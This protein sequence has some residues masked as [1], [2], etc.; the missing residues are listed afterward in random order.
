MT[1]SEFE[2][3]LR[4]AGAIAR[5]RD[6]FLIGS[7]SLRGVKS[8]IPRDFPK[9]IEAD[10]YPRRNAPAWQ[11]LRQKL[12]QGSRFF[13]RHGFY[14]DCTDP[15]LAPLPDGWTERLIPYRTP[16]TGGVTAWCLEPHDLFASKLVAGREK[17]ILFLRAM[18]RHKLVKVSL[19]RERI[20]GLSVPVS[21]LK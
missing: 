9:T 17:D 5:E 3:L 12:G 19:V 11:L 8:A 1:R 10:L 21:Q 6:F 18:L 13:D 2:L 14:L 20:A 15:G 7:Q 16:R 4:T